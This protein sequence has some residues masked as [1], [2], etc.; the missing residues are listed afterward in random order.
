MREPI[1]VLRQSRQGEAH[2]RYG[3]DVELALQLLPYPASHAA[4][5]DRAPGAE[6]ERSNQPSEC[7]PR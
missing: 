7:P 6:L 1:V 3:H 2:A 5:H 4:G